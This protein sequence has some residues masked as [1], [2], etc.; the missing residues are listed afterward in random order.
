[1]NV[2]RVLLVSIAVA[3]ALSGPAAAAAAPKPPSAPDAGSVTFQVDP[4]HDGHIVFANGFKPPLKQKWKVTLSNDVAFT[5]PIVVNGLVIVMLEGDQ[6]FLCAFDLATGESVWKRLIRETHFVY[7]AY[8]NGRVF[9]QEFSGVIDAFS[10]DR[11]GTPLWS[12]KLPPGSGYYTP[13]VAAAGHLIVSST[14]QPPKQGLFSLNEETGAIE[15]KSAVAASIGG[16]PAIAEDAVFLAS[17]AQF[18]KFDLATGKSLWFK[19]WGGTAG[20]ETTP[21]YFKNRLYVRDDGI[22]SETAKGNPVGT[23]GT[24]YAP[25][26]WTSPTGKD[27]EIVLNESHYLA[28]DPKTDNTVWDFAGNGHLSSLPLVIND[29]VIA[30]SVDGTLY[31]LDAARG[32]EL[33]E[34]QTGLSFPLQREL[35]DVLTGFG[36]GGD[37]LILVSGGS[38]AAFVQDGAR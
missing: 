7:A 27:L 21:V 20:G 29:M 30:G 5:Y 14:L 22:V 33:W 2:L 32:K 38:L 17:V 12:V 35:G 31:V 11:T 25:A 19:D 13:P 24:N 16:P 8:D 3:A 34:T 1:M 10:A 6:H 37:T 26:F 36:A 4:A 28:V 15:W 18:H 9:V 23:F